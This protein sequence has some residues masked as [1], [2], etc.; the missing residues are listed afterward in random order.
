MLLSLWAMALEA[1]KTNWNCLSG[2]SMSLFRN[3]LMVFLLA[4][5][6]DFLILEMIAKGSLSCS[7]SCDCIFFWRIFSYVGCLTNQCGIGLW[8]LGIRFLAVILVA[9]GV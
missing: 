4:V 1:C 6:M 7:R 8:S 2:E 3:Y 9:V 5:L